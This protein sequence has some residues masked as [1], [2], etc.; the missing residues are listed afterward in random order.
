MKCKNNCLYLK[1]NYCKFFSEY[2][3]FP[4]D[5]YCEM[6]SDEFLVSQY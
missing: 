1:K 2:I 6:Y 3:E 4:N 5:I